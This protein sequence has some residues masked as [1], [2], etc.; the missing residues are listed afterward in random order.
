MNRR[1]DNIRL[2]NLERLIKEANS[3]ANLAR[4][5]K[6]SSS[7]ISQVRNQLNTATGTPRTIG[8]ELS[9]RLER[10][11]GKKSG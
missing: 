2:K 7:Y 9:E 3:A 5:A 1:I 10:C 4:L 11:M 6:T 8:N